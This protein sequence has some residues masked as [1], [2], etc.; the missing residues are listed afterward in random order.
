MS[1]SPPAGDVR[2]YRIFYSDS[3]V[4]RMLNTS[5]VGSAVVGGLSLGV[6]YRFTVQA[7]ADFP[8]PNSTEGTVTLTG[9]TANGWMQY[10]VISCGWVC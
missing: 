8:S 6:Q 10:H 9:K 1:W 7:F 2:G 3:S 4:T 5:N